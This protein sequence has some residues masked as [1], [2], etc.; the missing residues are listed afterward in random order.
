[1]IIVS[2]S[3]FYRDHRKQA[4]RYNSLEEAV[5]MDRDRM[6]ANSDIMMIIY[7]DGTAGVAVMH[8]RIHDVIESDV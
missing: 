6:D 4:H 5:I 8:R 2:F 7:E 3:S 1:M